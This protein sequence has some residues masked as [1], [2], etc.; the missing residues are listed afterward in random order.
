M[1]E[2]THDQQA[3][4]AATIADMQQHI[5]KKVWS[6]TP[7]ADMFLIST[8]FRDIAEYALA[9]RRTRMRAERERDALRA[10]CAGVPDML[11]AL[12]QA[13]V[14]LGVQN[15]AIEATAKAAAI[16][17]A[18]DGTRSAGGV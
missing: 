8:N 6:E 4:D 11:L 7:D 12:A 1:S 18:L 15:V 17:A 13:S 9:E 10:A 5:D 3:A 14:N 2:T 16:R